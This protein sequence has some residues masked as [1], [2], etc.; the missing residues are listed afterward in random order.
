MFCEDLSLSQQISNR[1]LCVYAEGRTCTCFSTRSSQRSYKAIHSS[2]QHNSHREAVRGSLQLSTIK[3]N[4]INTL[5]HCLVLHSHL[6][7]T[8]HERLSFGP[9][10][11]GGGCIYSTCQLAFPSPDDLQKQR[12]NLTPIFTTPHQQPSANSCQCYET[13]FLGLI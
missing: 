13:S 5:F 6:T 1:L 11:T 8:I 3:S 2:Y 9:Q 7:G 12:C 4:I 10:H